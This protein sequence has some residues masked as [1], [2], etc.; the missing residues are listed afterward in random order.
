M[1]VWPWEFSHFPRTCAPVESD[2]GM[3][4]KAG[5]VPPQPVMLVLLQVC[6]IRDAFLEPFIDGEGSVNFGCICKAKSWFGDT[7]VKLKLIIIFN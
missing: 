6:I 1:K 7:N 2:R 5:E 3:V 4:I